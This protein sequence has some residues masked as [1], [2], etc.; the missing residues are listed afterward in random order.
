MQTLEIFV[1]NL[2]MV[3][4]V[5]EQNGLYRN[6][7]IIKCE[8]YELKFKQKDIKLEQK[9]F[10]NKTQVTTIIIVNIS[11]EDEINNILNI[12]DNI[13]WLLSFAQQSYVSRFGYRVNHKSKYA[14]CDGIV[15]GSMNNII[16]P[17]GEPIRSFVE[18]TY[19]TFKKIKDSR[20][21]SVVFG[22]LCEAN[23]SSLAFEISLISHYVAIENLKH[24]FALNNDYNYLKGFFYHNN[25]P[26]LELAP[27]DLENYFLPQG[28]RKKYVHKYFS[29]VNSSEMTQRMFEHVGIE[30]DNQAVK[31]TIKN[32]NKLI[33]EGILSPFNHTEYF[34]KARQD[35]N[36]TSNLIRLY[37]LRLLNY[38]GS[39]MLN[40][41]RLG[42][43]GFIN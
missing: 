16:E 28:K 43:S 35:L 4:E 21:L 5:F 14:T 41:D 22:Y 24:T 42:T 6:T 20:Q 8:G 18:Q 37:L 34:Q 31:N 12:V 7:T 17:R 38:K 39:Y 30:R 29:R 11:D 13:C 2:F 26:D 10:Y 23:R 3:G 25:Y 36:C 1:V 27:D 19:S 32:R 33:H 40:N 15:V 9:D